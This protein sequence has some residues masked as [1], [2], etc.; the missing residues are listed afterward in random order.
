MKKIYLITV[1]NLLLTF[2]LYSQEKKASKTTFAIMPIHNSGAGFNNVFL[3]SYEL[4]PR[5]KLTFYSVFWVNPSF[6]N[7]GKDLFLETGVGL[8][9]VSKNKKWFINPS[10]GFGHGKLLSQTAGTKI[11]ESI[12][13]SLFLVHNSGR[14][15]LE[16]YTAYYKSLRGEGNSQDLM[17]NWVIPGF[18]VN[19]HLSLGGFYEHLGQTRVDNGNKVTLYQFL[20]GYIKT[21]L[22]NGVWFRFAFGPNISNDNV[23]ANEFYKIQ[24]FIPI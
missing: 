15:E 18:K 8:G 1:I 23:N 5:K 14:F 10:L 4:K 17:L 16:A 24:A 19:K 6:G 2:T 9:F 12:I 22:D 13:P 20:G 7:Q 3:G 11:A 21:T